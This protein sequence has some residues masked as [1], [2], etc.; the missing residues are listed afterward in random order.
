LRLKLELLTKHTKAE[1]DVLL[2]DVLDASD[3]NAQHWRVNLVELE[4]EKE[5]HQAGGFL[6]AVKALFLWVETPEERMR[7][8][9]SLRLE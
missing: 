6:D 4:L 5:Q 2:Q 7:N 1:M 8:D 3:T 9:C